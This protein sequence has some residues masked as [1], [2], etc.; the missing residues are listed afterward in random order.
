MPRANRSWK[1][2]DDCIDRVKNLTLEKFGRQE[3]LAEQARISR[4]TV[5]K[6]LNG[7]RVDI[8]PFK[9]ISFLLGLGDGKDIACLQNGYIVAESTTSDLNTGAIVQLPELD[10]NQFLIY[11][12]EDWRDSTN[13]AF[14]G[15]RDEVTILEKW[16]F[17]DH[18]R[19][20]VLL[21]MGGIGKTSLALKFVEKIQD[22]F[23][24]TVWRS[25]RQAPPLSE[26]LTT[27]LKLI[28]PNP[29]ISLPDTISGKIACL[30]EYLSNTKCLIVLD[31]MESILA[32]ED[33]EDA[34]IQRGGYYRAGYEDYGELIQQLGES[35]HQ[36]CLILTSREKP[37]EIAALEGHETPVRSLVIRGLETTAAQCIVQTKQLSGTAT[38][39]N[40][41]IQRYDGN[42]LALKIVASTIQELFAGDVAEFLAAGTTFFGQIGELLDEQFNRLSPLEKHVMFWLAINQEA[43][44][45]A[46]LAT[47]IALFTSRRELLEAMESLGRRPLI[48]KHDNLFSQQPV[49]MEYMTERLIAQACKEIVFAEPSLLMSHALL[50]AKAKDY[51]RESQ[52]RLILNPIIDQLTAHFKTTDHIVSQCQKIVADLQQSDSLVLGYTAGNLINLLC[53]LQVN[54]TGFDFSRLTLW[55]A[56]LSH[57]NLHQVNLSHTDLEGTVFKEAFGGILSVDLS[58]DGKLLVAGGTDGA[59]RL[60]QVA[61]GKLLWVGKQHSNWVFS[62]AFSPNNKQIASGS[63][64]STVRLWDVNTGEQLNCLR[65]ICNEINAIAFSPT[66]CTLVIGGSEQQAKLVDV[67]TGK[68]LHTLQGH[69]GSRILAVVFS[70]DGQTVL[71][72]STDNT[73]KLWDVDAG[74]CL[75]TFFGHT[76]GVRSLVFSPNGETIA[77]GSIDCTIKLWQVD[78][79]Q[80]WQTL[81]GHQRMILDLAFSPEGSILTSAS[82]DSTLRLWQI[83][84]GRCLCLLVGHNKPVWSLV[85]NPDGRTIVS[86]GD[87]YAIKFWDAETG[88]C[89]KTWQGNSNAMTAVAY[90][91]QVAIQD[92]PSYWLA[93]GSEDHHI[94]LWDINNGQCQRTLVGHKGRVVSL[95]YSPDGQTLLSGSW[96]GM[97]KLWDIC[98]GQCLETFHGHTLLIWAVAFSMD[99][100]TLATGSED[101]TIRL[102][103][104]RGQCRQVLSE[105]QGAVHSIAF[106]PD[107]RTLASGGIDC[108]I[109]LWNIYEDPQENTKKLEGHTSPIRTMTFSADGRSL[110]STSKDLAI[111]VWNLDTGQCEKSLE[112]HREAVWAIALSP[113]GHVLASGGEDR[114]IK[115]WSL[116]SGKC[117]KTLTGHLSMIVSITFHPEKNLLVSGSLDET[118]KIWDIQ[119]GE[120]LRTL[121]V[122]RPYEGMNITGV[123]GLTEAQ[124]ATLRALGALEV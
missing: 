45:L 32:S 12:H 40:R 24:Y 23:K 10:V 109:R 54:L 33:L 49:V 4:S 63:G 66:G 73:L 80:C 120:C 92:N 55:Q 50:K 97:A 56:Y 8:A 100:H 64:D 30:L 111:K 110:I 6:Y 38:D 72:G 3:E 65:G 114:T 102:W 51:I 121:W 1:V 83:D 57:V 44:S 116:T 112:G 27:I 9:E 108:T 107:A 25:L 13:A 67:D 87:D 75:K 82:L 99:G 95:Q 86:G 123:I 16:I 42:P 69:N 76:D 96:D 58:S 5:S 41:L 53:Q 71:T 17:Q 104:I 117:L 85:Y 61:D 36:S 113:D 91:R 2:R 118:I 89:I 115:L 60:W 7:H 74:Y 77:S 31:N 59:V 21:G 70:P 122:E 34:S 62:V 46:E 84:V 101:G 48:E 15:R 35:L 26:T 52:I 81:T 124:K 106:S 88:Q 39:F 79:G 93:S 68:L 105:H 90:P 47:D 18:C 103:N 119:T 19:V 28:A 37:K 98:T 22:Q 43:V 78:S 14:Y 94:R 20:V 29:E 11:Q